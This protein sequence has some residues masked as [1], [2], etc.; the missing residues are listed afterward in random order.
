[1]VS[2]PSLHGSN[3]AIEHLN[4]ADKFSGQLLAKIAA[5]DFYIVGRSDGHEVAT[6]RLH[7]STTARRAAPVTMVTHPL[8]RLGQTKVYIHLGRPKGLT[9]NKLRCAYD[10]IDAQ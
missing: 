6:A 7:N 4:Q 9:G 10:G 1:M 3:I 2:F 5:I 8:G